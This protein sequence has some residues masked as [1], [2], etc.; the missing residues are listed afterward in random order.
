MLTYLLEASFGDFDIE[1]PAVVGWVVVGLIAGWIASSIMSHGRKRRGL[2]GKALLGMVGALV[3]GL[4]FSVAGLGGA[5][6][7]IGSIA[8]ATVGA[9]IILAIAGK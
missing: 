1:L 4:V 2:V 3:G 6:N 8:I 9:V 7:I 5:T